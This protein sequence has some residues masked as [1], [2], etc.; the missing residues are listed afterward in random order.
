MHSYHNIDEEVIEILSFT[1]SEHLNLIA[2]VSR[3]AGGRVSLML[4]SYDKARFLCACA[5]PDESDCIPNIIAM[6][7][8][9]P[10]PALVTCDELVRAGL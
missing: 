7:F 9:E 10:F 1:L 4:W 8:L 6:K 3:G 2:S 5:M